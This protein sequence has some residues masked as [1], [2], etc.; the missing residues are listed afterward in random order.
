MLRLSKKALFP[1]VTYV[2]SVFSCRSI[3]GSYRWPRMLVN[4]LPWRLLSLNSL[5]LS[6]PYKYQTLSV[7]ESSETEAPMSLG[8]SRMTFPSPVNSPGDSFLRG[9]SHLCLSESVIFSLLVCTRAK[10]NSLAI[11]LTQLHFLKDSLSECKSNRLKE[12][13]S[14][15][16]RRR[17]LSAC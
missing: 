9:G 5:H 8:Q 3:T 12:A 4:P 17:K 15:C 2:I 14:Q 6:M 16:S 10:E 1:A 13:R 7:A 11:V